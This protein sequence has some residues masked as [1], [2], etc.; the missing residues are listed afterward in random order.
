MY[1][2]I[3]IKQYNDR[4][5]T[6]NLSIGTIII[7]GFRLIRE[8]NSNFHIQ[9]P[10]IIEINKFELLELTKTALYKIGVEYDVLQCSEC[11]E[12]FEVMKT[13]G[14]YVR[15][16]YCNTQYLIPNKDKYHTDDALNNTIKVRDKNDTTDYEKSMCDIEF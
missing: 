9:I 11:K 13:D 5:H 15:C 4:I 1:R 14:C 10:D 8:N 3:N 6:F 12:R 2:I 16:D 7:T